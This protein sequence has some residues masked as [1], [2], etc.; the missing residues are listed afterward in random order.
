MTAVRNIVLWGLLIAFAVIMLI[1]LG[2]SDPDKL[3]G[4]STDN[5]MSVA[6]YLVWL[7]AIGASVIVLFRRQVGQAVK[8][9]LLWLAIGL[10]AIIGYTYRTEISGVTDRVMSELVPGRPVNRAMRTVEIVRG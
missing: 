10:A 4:L 5:F 2:K 6:Y 1:L 9:A 8:A 3:G 7:V